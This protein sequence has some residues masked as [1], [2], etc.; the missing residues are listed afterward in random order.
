MS[1]KVKIIWESKYEENLKEYEFDTK[2]EYFAFMKGVDESNG[3]LEYSAIGFLQRTISKFDT[4]EEYFAFMKGVDESN[5]WLEYTV[6]G[7]GD[8]PV[9]SIEEWRKHYGK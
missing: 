5:G 4:K 1:I 2:E 9:F 3:W 6:I 7:D 8:N